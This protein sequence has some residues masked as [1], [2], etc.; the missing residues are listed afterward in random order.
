M[1]GPVAAA[2]TLRRALDTKPIDSVGR[3]GVPLLGYLCGAATVLWDVDAFRR[4]AVAQ[5]DLTREL[6]A[7]SMLPGALNVLAQAHVFE[8]DLDA[9]A[10]AI[11]EAR[12]LYEATGNQLQPSVAALRAG[13]Q[14]DDDVAVLIAEQSAAARS[15]GVGL[16]LKS[17]HWAT[18]TL[19]NGRGE[20]E[21]ALAAAMEA[22]EHP[23]EWNTQ[24]FVHELIEAAA[25]TGRREA[26]GPTIE[27]FGE[28]VEASGSDWAIGMLAR[29]RALLAEGAHAED[30]YR[31][32]IDRLSQ[33]PDPPGARACAP[34]LRRVAPA[35]EP[36]RRRRAQLRTAHEMF[37]AM[38]IHGFAERGRATSSWRP[39]RPY[40][41]A[42]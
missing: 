11:A 32:A 24:F 21:Q 14:G 7:L 33:N 15:A 8:G 40:A 27:R 39:A 29:S 1:D 6:G 30:L 41:S 2:P 23:W 36:A 18:A 16:A 4:L 31:E 20:Y 12:E 42:P 37:T 17:A 28:Y 35:R 34:A 26:I 38:G 13:L 5:V 22:V 9:A 3:T 25:R 19:H 10:S